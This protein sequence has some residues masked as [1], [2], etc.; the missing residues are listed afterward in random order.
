MY[1]TFIRDDAGFRPT[2]ETANAKSIQISMML[3]PDAQLTELKAAYLIA[4]TVLGYSWAC[5]P[6]LDPIRQAIQTGDLSGL[7]DVPTF[8]TQELNLGYANTVIAE[9][10]S[11]FVAVIGDNPRLGVMLPNTEG[12][13][14]GGATT[15]FTHSGL[16]YPWL[17]D[18]WWW[19][20]DEDAFRWDGVTSRSQWRVDDL[21]DNVGCPEG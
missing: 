3:S 14:A 10:T 2:G 15:Q 13:S 7:G 19:R 17:S 21:P 6:Q 8:L 12:L 9:Q 4:F 20:S 18:G 11:S 16:G 5:R 1:G